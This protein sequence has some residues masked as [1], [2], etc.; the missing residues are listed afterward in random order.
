MGR[1]GLIML[2]ANVPMDGS[3]PAT[4]AHFIDFIVTKFHFR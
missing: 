4:P 2:C 3:G 1:A